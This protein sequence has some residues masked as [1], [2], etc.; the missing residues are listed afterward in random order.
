MVSQTK[1][2]KIPTRKILPLF[3]C[4]RRQ[5]RNAGVFGSSL[6]TADLAYEAKIKADAEA[7]RIMRVAAKHPSHYNKTQQVE[8]AKGKIK[9]WRRV[10]LARILSNAS[11]SSRVEVMTTLT[12]RA[13]KT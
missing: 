12:H 4:C 3:F 1:P 9:D 7:A 6:V 5:S 13:G 11:K 8:A 2:R 10:R